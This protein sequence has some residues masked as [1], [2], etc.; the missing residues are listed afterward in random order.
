MPSKRFVHGCEQ[1]CSGW[2]IFAMLHVRLMRLRGMRRRLLQLV[3]PPAPQARRWQLHM[4]RPM[5]LPLQ[6]TLPP[7]SGML[8]DLPIPMVRR[9][10]NASGSIGTCSN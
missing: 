9:S 8:T 6:G 10:R 7:R 1:A 2:L 4:F 3:L 5:P